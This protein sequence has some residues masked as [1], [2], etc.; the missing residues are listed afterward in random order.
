MFFLGITAGI[1]AALTRFIMLVVV[2]C[3]TIA[4]LD[5]SLLAQWVLKYINLD[6]GNKAYLATIFTYHL[7][8]HPIMITFSNILC[9]KLIDFS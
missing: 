4:R 8:N 5:Q 9:M 6:A 1:A 7:H 3:F 2:S